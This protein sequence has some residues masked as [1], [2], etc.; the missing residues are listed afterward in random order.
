M[1]L[2][3]AKAIFIMP[4]FLPYLYAD[5]TVWTADGKV[6]T[7]RE[8]KIYPAGEKLIV[9]LHARGRVNRWDANNILKIIF[10]V[11]DKPGSP[12]AY[13]LQIKLFSQDI[14]FG[15]MESADDEA[16]VL[17]TPWDEGLRIPVKQICWMKF[18]IHKGILPEQDPVATRD[19]RS[20]II[21]NK[22]ETDTGPIQ[23]FSKK[24]IEWR[25]KLVGFNRS[26]SFEERQVAA[27]YFMPLES[28][29]PIPETLYGIL[30]TVNGSAIRAQKINFSGNKFTLESFYGTK[31]V[32]TSSQ[33]ANLYFKNG[34]VVYLSDLKPIEVKEDPNYVRDPN[35]KENLLSFPY[36]MDKSVI[37]TPLSMRGIIYEKG[38]G[39][40]SRSSLTF[41]LDKKYRL[42][43]AVIGL[44]DCAKGRGNV[45]FI[46]KADGKVVKGPIRMTGADKPRQVEVSVK[47][48][49]RLTLIV[50]FGGEAH[51]LDRADW[52]DAR[53]IK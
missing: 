3:L 50:D 6:V 52:A 12:G 30:T 4:L 51:I 1:K 13:D 7:G 24:G 5:V 48:V 18:L 26:L 46:I 34:N 42:F 45:D 17:K 8:L 25:S 27:V 29:P 20:I 16:I 49:E 10:G 32:F 44:D 22:G 21:D 43:Q 47:G 19:T 38:I 23:S 28:P 9:S 35:S 11:L 53:L 41:S 36:K 14:L 15:R 39:V 33:V 40:H 2:C 31:F 37:G